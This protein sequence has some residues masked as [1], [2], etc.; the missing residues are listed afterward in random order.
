MNIPDEAARQAQVKILRE[1]A[2]VF[3]ARAKAGFDQAGRLTEPEASERVEYESVG[4]DQ[5][6]EALGD[7]ADELEAGAVER[8]PA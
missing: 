1:M 7:K 2:E 5:A 3:R 6:A 8:N 4:F